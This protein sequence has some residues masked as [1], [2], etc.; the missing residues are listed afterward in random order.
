MHHRPT[1]RGSLAV[2]LLWCLT[3]LCLSLTAYARPAPATQDTRNGKAQLEVFFQDL[4]SL[5]ATFEQTVLD[6]Q[7]QVSQRMSGTVELARPMKFHWRY[8]APYEQDIVADG[9]RLWLYDPD[10]GQ[11]TVKSLDKDLQGT[12]AALLGSRRPLEETFLIR[13]LDKH[14]GLAW[15]ELRPR[16]EDS[17]FD[18]IRMGFS[19]DALA[20]MELRDSF[21]QTSIITFGKLRK[22][23]NIAPDEFAFEPPPGADVIYD[24]P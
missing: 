12:P 18:S 10:L 3:A 15:V 19:G 21:G 17:G 16:N 6:P 4:D 9:K 13:E 24:D 5:S 11:V 1:V 20:V 23:I 7:G 8:L 14:N 2:A 22:N